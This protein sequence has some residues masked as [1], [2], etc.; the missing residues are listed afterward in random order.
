MHLLHASVRLPL[1]ESISWRA[2]SWN[3]GVQES[4]IFSATSRLDSSV[5]ADGMRPS[6]RLKPSMFHGSVV[7]RSK[8]SAAKT[9]PIGDV[10]V[11]VERVC[12]VG[13]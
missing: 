12:H 1:I 3:A 9:E 13:M 10:S 7:S 5:C 2:M 11:A 8:A 4:M 6:S